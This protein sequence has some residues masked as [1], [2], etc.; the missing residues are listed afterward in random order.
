MLISQLNKRFFFFAVLGLTQGLCTELHSQPFE[1]IFILKQGFAKSLNC[2]DRKLYLQ[3]QEFSLVVPFLPCKCKILSFIPGT[4]GGKKSIGRLYF[5]GAF[6]YCSDTTWSCS[7][8]SASQSAG[9]KACATTPITEQI[10][11][12]TFLKVSN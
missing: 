11:L 7:P 4:G 8:T 1:N 2:S 10:L 9:S 12:K 6:L 3:G 5:Q